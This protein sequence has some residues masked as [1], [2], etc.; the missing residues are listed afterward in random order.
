MR[1]ITILFKGEA[2]Y[3]W[4]DVSGVR[5]WL[6]AQAADLAQT[7][8][9]HHVYGYKIRYHC[10]SLAR[11]GFMNLE[12]LTD[13]KQYEVSLSTLFKLNQIEELYQPTPQQLVELI[14]E[15]VETAVSSGLLFTTPEDW[16]AFPPRHKQWRT[17]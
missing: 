6:P 7:L 15:L 2:V 14:A 17:V 16:H 11:F 12:N 9:R 5:E 13:L 4:D 10:G 3:T 1:P 8:N